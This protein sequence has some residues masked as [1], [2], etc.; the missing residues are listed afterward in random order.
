MKSVMMGK[1]KKK[2]NSTIYLLVNK[3]NAKPKAKYDFKCRK[4]AP[5]I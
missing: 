5:K 2:R 4:F 3:T 1:K